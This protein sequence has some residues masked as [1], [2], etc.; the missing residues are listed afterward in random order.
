MSVKNDLKDKLGIDRLNDS[1]RKKLY[2]KFLDGGGEVVGEK[3]KRGI[4][5]DREKQKEWIKKLKGKKYKWRKEFYQDDFKSIEEEVFSYGK[6]KVSFKTRVLVYLKGIFNQTITIGGKKVN[7][8]FFK[9]IKFKVIP[10]LKNL[11][12]I[13]KL[14]FSAG[15]KSL[16]EVKKSLESKSPYYY[17]LLIKLN[18]LFNLDEFNS[19]LY[20]Y[21]K[22]VYKNVTPRHL[23]EPVKKIMKEIYLLRGFVAGMF[24]TL[25]TSLFITAKYKKWDK[26]LYQRKLNQIKYSLNLIFYHL[27]PKLYS[28]IL[29]IKEE[30]FSL[31]SNTM[32]HY[33]GIKDSDKVDYYTAQESE[34]QEIFP[35][36]TPIINREEQKDHKEKIIYVSKYFYELDETDFKNMNLDEITYNGMLLIKEVDLK[37]I[38]EEQKELL[39]LE[40]CPLDDK[41][42]NVFVYIKEFEKEYSF[43]LTSYKII[44]VPTFENNKR[45]DYKNKLIDMYT[46]LNNLNELMKDYFNTV[47]GIEEIKNDKLMNQFD[48]Y[49]RV[50]SFE[51]KRSKQSF[52]L[53]KSALEY[54]SELK[55]YLDKFIND[56]NNQRDI[57]ENPEDELHFDKEVEGEK[58]V[59]GKKI[60]EAIMDADAFIS[61][62]I[63]RLEEGGD[64][65][66]IKTEVIQFEIPVEKEE[67][68][69]GVEGEDKKE[70]EQEPS[71]LDEVEETLSKT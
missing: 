30:N 67:G 2:N 70:E 5:F 43:I 40:Y 59:E 33:L 69:E 44:I 23:E 51:G 34:V 16:K 45:V 36:I 9:F 14:I 27:L 63:Y 26:L 6:K 54:F 24:T 55:Q 65:S 13:L 49:N 46:P 58:K 53:K 38:F 29:L 25:R 35:K 8:R 10:N 68:V 66:G 52:E 7:D 21:N 56:Y 22:S 32:I 61:T 19:L 41:V 18:E 20:F 48:K 42:L 37:K 50:T 17:A 4:E 39:P 47:K 60:I 62:M 28:C 31:R 1:Q 64:L 12:S 3:N 71:F 15:N 57:I 11:D